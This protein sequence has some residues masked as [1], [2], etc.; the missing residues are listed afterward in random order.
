[1]CGIVGII[2][3]ESPVDEYR[4]RL[5]SMVE[6]LK[7]RG[8][9][10]QGQHF[11]SEQCAFGHTRLSIVD[12]KTGQQPMLTP[13][14]TVSVTFN[15]EL[16][17][18]QEI[19][20]RLSYPFKT[21]SDTEVLLALYRN[22]GEEMVAQ[23]P[24]MFAF[25]LWDNTEKKL[26]CARDR[27]GEKPF[28]YA[29]GGNGEFI[30]GSE[31]KSILASGLVTPILDKE[32]VAYYLRHL[33]I[34]PTRTVY[35]NIFTLPPAHRLVYQRG[36]IAVSRYWQFPTVNSAI[37]LTDAKDR[38][39]NLLSQAVRK[40][41]V[42]DVP[43]GAFLSGGLDSSTI[44]ALAS[45]F[46]PHLKTFSFAFEGGLDESNFAREVA[47]KYG[48][49]HTEL[50]AA[51]V[52]VASILQKMTQVY[53][54]P[55]ADSSN[56]PTYILAG[57]AKQHAT[58]VLTGDG[59][60][61]LLGGYAQWYQPLLT[62]SQLRPSSKEYMSWF[63]KC[64]A[65]LITLQKSQAWY[66]YKGW[67]LKKQYPSIMAAHESQ[68]T[69]FSQSEILKL[70]LKNPALTA[71]DSSWAPINSLDDAMRMDLE[72]YMPGDI[73]VKTD[74]AAMAHALELRAPFLD[75]DFAEFC[76]SLPYTLKINEREEK[77]ILR[78]ACRSLWPVSVQK[79]SKQG[80]GAPVERWLQLAGVRK[81]KEEY[82]FNQNVKLWKIIP[83][84][85]GQEFAQKD[86]YQTWTL[87][88]LS[89]WAEAHS[90]NI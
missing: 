1:M 20:Q 57:L 45:R 25:A 7:H 60:D 28:Y 9:D 80:F 63:A 48:T 14:Q 67:R 71:R 83:F 38:F 2:A 56:I 86:S 54:E 17:G 87:L 27:F 5:G 85:Q 13:D 52:D 6:A 29:V 53:D 69:Y 61:E 4:S 68:N 51:T 72:N 11:F 64:I 12:L 18:Y 36:E 30:F 78:E 37:T 47:Q 43:V 3:S 88:V 82:L 62:M 59:G 50:S 31:I 89:M 40:Q 79:R 19:R 10:E 32:M 34:H 21:N 44:T 58:V 15:G 66:R 33:Y 46:V 39:T 55:F 49:D 75:V 81:L 90:F 65:S 8:P 16:Y 73:L 42:A 70:G 24:G 76:I 84:E 74:R 41:L 35:K 23:V 77:I 22:Y 26:I